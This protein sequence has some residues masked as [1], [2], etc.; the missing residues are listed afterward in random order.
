MLLPP[1]AVKRILVYANLRASA[2]TINSIY[3]KPQG[4]TRQRSVAP[5]AAGEVCNDII[6]GLEADRDP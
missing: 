4:I 6:D 5:Q 3:Q 1:G 2:T